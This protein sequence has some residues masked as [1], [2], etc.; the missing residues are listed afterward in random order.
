MF[1]A[2]LIRGYTV[3]FYNARTISMHGNRSKRFK[4]KK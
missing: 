4:K 1:L 2:V 3:K